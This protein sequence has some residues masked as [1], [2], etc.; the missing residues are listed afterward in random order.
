MSKPIPQLYGTG[1][2]TNPGSNTVL[3]DTG[4]FDANGTF[5]FLILLSSDVASTMEIQ[6]RNAGNNA[7][8]AAQRVFLSASAPAQHIF[9]V[10]AKLNERVRVLLISAI[11]GNACALISTGD[12]KDF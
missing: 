1:N 6:Y 5:K 3:A 2:Q 8:V 11:T 4:Q 12:L 7:N 10:G 9:S